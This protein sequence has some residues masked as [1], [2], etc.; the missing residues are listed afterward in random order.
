MRFEY[1]PV[2][3]WPSLAWLARCRA[4]GAPVTV[5]HG[6]RVETAGEWFCEAAWAGDYEAGDFD[7]TDIVAGSGGRLR[8]GEVVF[9]SPGSTVDRLHS[10]EVEDG[11]WVSNSLPCLL[12]TVDGRVDASYAWYFRVLRTIIRGID[13]Y[14]RFLDTSVGPV[15]L[16]YFDNLVWD[17]RSLGLRAK[18]GTGRDFSSFARYRAFLDDSM[19]ALAGNIAAAGRRYPYEFMGTAS[20]GYDS[21]TVTTLAKQVGCTQALCFDVAGEGKEDSGEPLCRALGIKAVVVR[22]NAWRSLPM[23]EVPF[24]AADSDGGDIFFRSAEAHLHGKVL[25]TGFHGDKIWAKNTKDLSPYIRRGDP[26]GLSLTEYRLAAGFL[27]CPVPFWGVRQIREVNAISNAPEM[28]PWDIPGVYS[29]PICRRIVEEAGV[30]RELFG[31]HKKGLWGIYLKSDQFLTEQSMRDYF[32]WLGAARA[33]WLRRGRI[34]PLRSLKVDG[35]ERYLR[36]RVM[37]TAL[38]QRGL[39]RSALRRSGLLHVANVLGDHPTRLRKFV[40]P[41]A[42]EHA[43]EAYPQPAPPRPSIPRRRAAGPGRTPR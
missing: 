32:A 10:L 8:D 35:A 27:H 4:P 29:R 40:F 1:V 23:P 19:Q 39:R 42:L 25:L 26:S 9:V 5:F 24:V 2:P 34:P 15:Q 22:Q 20:S 38:K 16:T 11:A 33:E 18:P 12:A 13:K 17:G 7:R 30:P 3:E 31:I 37:R 36:Y 28:K 14:R 6:G 21:A 41:W 43:K